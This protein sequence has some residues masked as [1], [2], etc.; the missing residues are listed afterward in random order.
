M[1][2]MPHFSAAVLRRLAD[3]NRAE[4]KR[5]SDRNEVIIKL[6]SILQNAKQLVRSGILVLIAILFKQGFPKLSLYKIFA[7]LISSILKLN[8]INLILTHYLQSV[9]FGLV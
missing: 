8:F 4:A 7:Y 6:D 3:D 1:D 9:Q 2:A 5:Q